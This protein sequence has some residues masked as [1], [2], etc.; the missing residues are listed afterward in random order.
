MCVCACMHMCTC[1]CAT[2]YHSDTLSTGELRPDDETCLELA[3]TYLFN[4]ETDVVD[5]FP[6]KNKLLIDSKETGS[7]TKILLS[8][9]DGRK[10]AP[11]YP[12][13]GKLSQLL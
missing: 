10:R 1:V 8:C 2:W 13:F 11:I 12:S 9:R 7:P 5:F 3:N 4:P 6:W